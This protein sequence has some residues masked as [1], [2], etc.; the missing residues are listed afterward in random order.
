[1]CLV[2]QKKEKKAEIGKGRKKK[3]AAAPLRENYDE[4]SEKKKKND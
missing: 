3:V 4:S 2:L 1:M